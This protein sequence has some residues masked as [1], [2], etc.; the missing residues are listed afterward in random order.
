[1]KFA[2]VAGHQKIKE[3]LIHTVK[4]GRMPHAQ[5]FLGAEG[6]G[7]LPMAFAYAQY[8]NCKNPL[9]NDS[10]GVCP[11]CSKIQKLEHPDLHL[12]FPMKGAKATSE[13]F[14]AEFRKIVLNNPYLAV[15]D[16]MDELGNENSLPN[17]TADECRSIIKKL[18]LKPY[19][20]EI[21]I[22]VM[23]LP[24]YLGKEG[25]ILLKLIEEPPG[26]ALLILCCENENKLLG[27]ILSRVQMTR[28]PAYSVAEIASHLEINKD[29]PADLAQNIA[30]MCG[31][32]MNKA[33]HMTTNIDNTYLD[34]FRSWLLDCY[35]GSSQK[36]DYWTKELSAL[37]REPLKA[38][39]TYGLQICRACLVE[40]Y[41]LN[42]GRLTN[43]EQDF[44]QRLSQL[45]NVDALEEFYQLLSQAQYSIERNGNAKIT[46]FDL[47]LKI[48]QCLRVSKLSESN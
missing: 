42:E 23:W 39:F 29:M 13:D 40:P 18:G 41:G 22:L 38:F 4:E 24:E 46:I 6:T 16:W 27:T 30:L 12:S 17:I 34:N 25:N 35:K 47:S 45:M 3:K 2:E 19:E 11:S 10:C 26:N 5:I 43:N 44:V 48:H 7:I 1:M 32:N 8:I 31:G 21:K 20:E 15:T 9:D 33:L 14:V 37:G 36:Y 28:F